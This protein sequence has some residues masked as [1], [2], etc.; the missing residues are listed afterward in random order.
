MKQNVYD[1]A[2][3]D[4]SA[5]KREKKTT[6]ME[7]EEKLRKLSECIP[8][9]QIWLQNSQNASLKTRAVISLKEN[10]LSKCSLRQNLFN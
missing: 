7:S 10:P 8:E 9:R 5:E 2:L 4:V 6:Q 1:Q 3:S